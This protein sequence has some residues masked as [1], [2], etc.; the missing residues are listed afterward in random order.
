MSATVEGTVYLFGGYRSDGTP[1]SAAY[2]FDG[3]GWRPVADLPEPRAAGTAVGVSGRVY[4]A[5]GIGPGKA[6]AGRMLVYDAAAD[7]WSTAPGPPTAREHLG[8]AGFGGLVYTVGGRTARGNLAAF[9]SYDPRTG[10]WAKLTDLPTPRGGLGAAA[11]CTGHVVAVGG[12]A[13]TT[14]KEAEAFDV[15]AGRWLALPPLPLARH[16]LGVAAVGS[17]LFTLAGGPQPGL[18]VS[19][20][21]QS[22]DLG[23]LRSCAAG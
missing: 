10:A 2:R 23:P 20:A 16:G 11:V 17:R 3:S 9:E 4:L 5:G 8:G 18:H 1:S 22:I 19:A 12:E 6:L 7:R 21:A 13:A 14:F 15:K